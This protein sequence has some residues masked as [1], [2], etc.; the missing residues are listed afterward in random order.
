MNHLLSPLKVKCS[1]DDSPL[2]YSEKNV[3]YLL[4]FVEDADS[5]GLII[6]TT[7]DYASTDIPTTTFIQSLG[8][9]LMVFGKHC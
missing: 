1:D 8:H 3:K 7:S 4:A 6:S 2:K 5:H 9:T